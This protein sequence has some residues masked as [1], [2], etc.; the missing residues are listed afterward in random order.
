MK[1]G[2][3]VR[4]KEG[5]GYSITLPGWVGVIT[6]SEQGMYGGHSEVQV[7]FFMNGETYPIRVSCLELLS[8]HNT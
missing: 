8:E 4:I 6:S 3:I 2:D 5:S 1:K 7:W